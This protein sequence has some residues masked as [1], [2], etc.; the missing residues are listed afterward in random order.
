MPVGLS[1]ILTNCL[2]SRTKLV[3][4]TQLFLKLS[5]NVRKRFEWFYF[6]HLNILDIFFSLNRSPWNIR[7]L[8]SQRLFQHIIHG[9]NRFQMG[10]IRL[11]YLWQARLIQIFSPSLY[12][13]NFVYMIEVTTSKLRKA[14]GKIQ[15]N[16]KRNVLLWNL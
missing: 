6:E 1:I 3:G 4:S 12:I 15:I 7:T 8:H 13:L 10:I 5:A 11:K 14:F 16:L 9:G 2:C